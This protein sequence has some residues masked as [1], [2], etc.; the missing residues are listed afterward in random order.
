MIWFRMRIMKAKAL[1]I[2]VIALSALLLSSGCVQTAIYSKVKPDGTI[3]DF[4]FTLNTSST[5]YHLLAQSAKEE[6]Y[7][8]LREMFSD[9]TY[10]SQN[11]QRGELLAGNSHF[12]YT[13]E[14]GEGNVRMIFKSKVPITPDS[15]SGLQIYRDGD[16]LVYRHAMNSSTPQEPGSEYSSLAS[17]MFPLDYYLEMPG[18]IVESNAN[19]IQGNKAEWHTTLGGSGYTEFYAKSELPVSLPGFTFVHGIFSIVIWGFIFTI[20]KRSQMR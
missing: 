5:V 9:P 16:H 15:G 12:E 7:S 6:G 2:L 20:S 13:E 10:Y 11:N 17:S 19:S 1:L 4:T 14:W 8:S 18:K 3:S